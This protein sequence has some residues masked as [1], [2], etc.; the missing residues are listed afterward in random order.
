M[1][2][3]NNAT[4]HFT[5]RTGKT[6]RSDKHGRYTGPVTGDN[7][8]EVQSYTDLYDLIV[9]RLKRHIGNK[10]TGKLADK[11]RNAK[12]R[13]RKLEILNKVGETNWQALKDLRISD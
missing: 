11:Y 13:I 10:P 12:I 2:N 3:I 1:P 6:A 5:A 8:Q 7:L 9:M 4:I